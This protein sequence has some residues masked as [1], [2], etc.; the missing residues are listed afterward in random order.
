MAKLE[1]DKEE[2]ESAYIL[3]NTQ[4][5]KKYIRDFNQTRTSKQHNETSNPRTLE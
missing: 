1:K 2:I 3:S 4:V 5:N